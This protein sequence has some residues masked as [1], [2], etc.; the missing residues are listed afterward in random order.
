MKV[1][2][3]LKIEWLRKHLDPLKTQ[4]DYQ[5]GLVDIPPGT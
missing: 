4:M 1:V 2:E 5:T 3:L